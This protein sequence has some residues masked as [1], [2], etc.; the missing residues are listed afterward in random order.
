[1]KL[2]EKGKRVKYLEITTCEEN[3]C[4]VLSENIEDA[5]NK[6]Y[7]ETGVDWS[8]ADIKYSVTTM[9]EDIIKSAL[10]LFTVE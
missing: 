7:R 6:M 2:N 10:V 5:L 8:I 9:G 1:M 3:F 4:K